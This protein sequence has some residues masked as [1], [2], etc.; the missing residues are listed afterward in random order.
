MARALHGMGVLTTID[1]AAL[2]AY[3]Q[4]YGRWVEA[5]ERL[6]ET[7]MLFRTP[8]GYVQQSPWLGIINKQLELMG[9]Y[10][11]EMG[12]TPAAR[13]RVLGS[14]RADA[15]TEP[16]RI[17]RIIDPP[18]TKNGERADPGASMTI[19][20]VAAISSH[21]N[22]LT[23]HSAAL[24]RY[25]TAQRR[26][27]SSVRGAHAHRRL[28]AGLDGT[29]GRERSRDRGAAPGD[30]GPCRADGRRGDRAVHRSGERAQPG[31]AG[32]GEGAA[33]G[34]GHRGDAGDRQAR[35]AVAQCRLPADPARQRRALRGRGPARGERPHRR[36]HG[37]G[38]PAGA[39][40]DLAAHAR[41][42]WRWRRPA[43]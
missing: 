9:R 10:M 13:S 19:D 29:A 20:R 32:T 42:R 5:E 21:C 41:R 22:D 27:R 15:I 4:A 2:A 39:R 8:S 14:R 25:R 12:M 38:G 7:P 31:P 35:P 3:C 1:R 24:P 16:I 28:R 40:G 6:R 11:T 30:R 34:Q 23:V 33:S 37:A 17:E 26:L 36:H 43:A 18:G